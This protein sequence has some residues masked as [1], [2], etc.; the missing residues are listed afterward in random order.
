MIMT[1]R[2][3]GSTLARR[4]LPRQEVEKGGTAPRAQLLP[5]GR[6][7]GRETRHYR[8][9]FC[10]V[11]VVTVLDATAGLNHFSLLTPYCCSLLTAP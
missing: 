3:E 5:S 6:A 7:L 10:R 2:G 9:E 11:H 4:R 1:A 8:V